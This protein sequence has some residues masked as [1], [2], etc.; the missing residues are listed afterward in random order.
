MKKMSFIQSI[1]AEKIKL[2]YKTI[3]LF[4]IIFLLTSCHNKEKDCPNHLSISNNTAKD[5]YFSLQGG[6]P[7]T[8]I[9]SYNPIGSPYDYKIIAN[10]EKQI[11]PGRNFCIND[12]LKIYPTLEL[13]LFDA[14]T[15]L[16]VPW[17][18]IRK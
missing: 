18:T 16:T 3:V 7:D 6:Y 12:D 2:L 4:L 10:S 11:S 8:T 13:F 14:N 15:L 17:D 5:I 9:G 1:F